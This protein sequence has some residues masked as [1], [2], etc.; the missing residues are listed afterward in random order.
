[1]RETGWRRIEALTKERSKIVRIIRD[2]KIMELPVEQVCQG[3]TVFVPQGEM[4]PVDG[5]S[6]E[7]ASS[8]DESVVTGEPF[9]LFKKASDSATSGTTSLTSQLKVRAARAVT[10]R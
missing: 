9:L 3:D 4:M 8:I 2:G 10:R 6:I 1:V 5:D 7:G